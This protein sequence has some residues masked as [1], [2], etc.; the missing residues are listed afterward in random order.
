MRCSCIP[1]WHSPQDDNEDFDDEE[2]KGKK[3]SKGNSKD[4]KVRKSKNLKL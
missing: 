1:E 2:V 4:F 3:K